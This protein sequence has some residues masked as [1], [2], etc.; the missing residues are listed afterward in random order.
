MKIVPTDYSKNE[1]PKGYKCKGG[2]V[3]GVK[4]WR[5]YQTF[6]NHQSLLCANCGSKKQG[7]D[8]GDID[9]EGFH[10]QEGARTDTI[11]WLVLAV[12]TVEGDTFWGYT[13]VPMDGVNW[14][15]KLPN[16]RKRKNE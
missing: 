4:L 12:P 16:E 14:W 8:I 13:S 5:E 11:G 7:K 15:R 1:T 6:L 2:G 10:G 3:S 9:A